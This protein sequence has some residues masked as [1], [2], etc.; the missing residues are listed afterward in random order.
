MRLDKITREEHA[1]I[2]AALRYYQQNGQGNPGNR[3]NDTQFIATDGGELTSLDDE[4][5]DALCEKIN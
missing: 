2:L 5:I 1:T 3:D 4:A